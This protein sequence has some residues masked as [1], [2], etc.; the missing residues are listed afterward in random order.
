MKALIAVLCIA[1]LIAI[2]D[3]P[4]LYRKHRF[5][6]MVVYIVML[7][8]G[9]WFSTIA[10]QAKETSSPLILIEIIYKP[11]NNLFSHLFNL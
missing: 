8:F 11:V 10:A 6:D 5:K 9:A 4:G 1:L 2:K 3:L 7:A